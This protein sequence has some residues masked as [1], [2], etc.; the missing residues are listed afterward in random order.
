MGTAGDLD[1]SPHAM[2]FDLSESIERVGKFPQLGLGDGIDFGD[3]P[4]K[5]IAVIG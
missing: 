2:M 5:A 3:K 1:L 4:P